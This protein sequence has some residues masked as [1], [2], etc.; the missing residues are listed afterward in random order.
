M[1]TGDMRSTYTVFVRG[2]NGKKPLLWLRF[3]YNGDIKVDRNEIGWKTEG[4][5]GWLKKRT[6]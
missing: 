6:G 2:S 3:K 4:R 5:F 1:A